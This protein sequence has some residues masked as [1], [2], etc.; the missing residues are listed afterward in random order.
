MTQVS[1]SKKDTK[2]KK[3]K[4][5]STR[6]REIIKVFFSYN[7]LQN[8]AKQTHPE[9]VRTAFEQ[10]GPTFIK[11]G[12]MLSVRTDIMTPAFIAEMRKLQDSVKIDPF[13][14]V[15]EVVETE[16]GQSLEEVFQTFEEI[17]FASAS[18]GQTHQAIL[19][20]GERVAVK[21]QHPGIKEEIHLDLSLFAKALPLMKYLPEAAVIDPKE[22]FREVKNSLSKE[23]DWLIEAENG[24]EFYQLNN[25]WEVIRV[26]KF[27]QQY[28]TP[29][30]L[31][32]EFMEGISLKE[33]LH[34]EPQKDQSSEAFQS[35]K[36]QIAG[37]L[38]RNF[39]KQIFDDGFFHAD[40][41]PGNL[42]LDFESAISQKMNDPQY[43]LVFLDFGM[44]GR[45]N[46]NTIQK[47]TE[48]MACL[49]LNHPKK[50]GRAVLRLCHQVGPV[51]EAVFFEELAPLLENTYG[52]GLGE[53][54]LQQLFFQIIKICRKNNL[55]VPQEVTLLVKA[56]ATFEGVIRQLD[57]EISLVKIA[58]LFAKK[59]VT[60]KMD[61]SFELKK[62]GLELLGSASQAPKIPAQ[63]ADVLDD[64]A[65]G[66][67]KINI[68]LK[69]QKEWFSQAE[70]LVNRF[71]IGLI[72]SALIIGSSLLV[73]FHRDVV[74]DFANILGV[75]GYG[76]ALVMILFLVIDSWRKRRKK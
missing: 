62:I 32:M 53:M 38:V 35:T 30:L 36:K 43:Q 18:M 57:P 3:Q 74:A 21:V 41:H 29:K 31:V 33:F 12:Q 64:L 2:K 63:T 6:L 5:G 75:I 49:Y 45:L 7:V 28:T 39:I 48:V 60:E 23:L 24:Q 46:H 72:I 10:L 9:K 58:S 14:T 70:N 66:K 56:M 71:V 51:D 40:P 27:Y 13:E 19:K 52:V 50:I 20:S 69:R 17:P 25:N 47:L 61:W 4:G 68:E 34:E 26:P 55:Q 73:A 44:M 37:L 67:T 65:N 15:R 1:T 22:T 42:L 16:L 59:Y 8:L 76:L 54:N 11:I